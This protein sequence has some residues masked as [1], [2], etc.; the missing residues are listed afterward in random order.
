MR[1]MRRLLLA[2][3][4][5][6]CAAAP[7][8]P[9]GPVTLT[10]LGTNDRHGALELLP[11]LAGYV[12]NVRAA[13]AADGGAVLLLDGGD[14]FQGTLESNLAEGAPVVAAMNALGYAAT[15][16]GNHEFDFGPVGPAIV[17]QAP[18]DDPRGALK[19]RIAE[20]RFPFLAANLLDQATGQHVDWVP[21]S[22]MVETAG[23]KVGIVGA[24][25]EAT[26]VT[27]MPANFK[28]LAMAPAAAAITAEARRL[29]A[30][31]ATVVVVVAHLGGK[32][33]KLSDPDDLSSCDPSEEIMKVAPAIP[34]GLVDVIVAGHTHAAM[35]HRIAGIAIIEAYSSGRAFGRVDLSVG[36]GGVVAGVRIHPPRDLCPGA[37]GKPVAAAA[38]APGDYEGR[39]VVASPAMA[40]VVAP[41]L[42]RARQQREE[43]VGVELETAIPRQYDLESAEGNLFADLL[44]AARPGADVGLVNGGSLRAELPAGRL[45]FGA[46]YQAMP[47]DN[48][49]AVVHMRGK[50][51]RTA[52]AANLESSAG[53]LSLGGATAAAACRGDRLVVELRDRA[54]KPIDDDRPLAVVTSDF[55]A[56]GGDGVIGRLHLPD[57]ATQVAEVLVRDAMLQA[58]R[59]QRGP[60]SARELLDPA[61]PRIAYPGKRPVR[62]DAQAR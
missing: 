46:F 52:V 53:I 24:L 22:T 51:L 36:P 6:A 28:G 55:L 40:Q 62:C 57:G 54:G 14:L 41:A 56:S 59:A 38:C 34:P 60:I 35:A 50:D 11:I 9:R 21:S 29:R 15:A 44:L 32:C 17:A 27:T 20:A 42:E 47:F 13:R 3:S 19:A 25:T 10:I 8:R 30:A 58:L 26:A 48:R 12:D 43:P 7:A 31:G 5:A 4:L 49:L 33:T 45:T 18:G 1:A 23:V 37:G 39:P 61:R 16:V 2:L